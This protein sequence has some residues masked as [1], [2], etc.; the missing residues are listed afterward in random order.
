MAGNLEDRS[1]E[2]LISQYAKTRNISE[3]AAEKA[4]PSEFYLEHPEAKADYRR[5][6]PPEEY[7]HV[8]KIDE[9]IAS[10]NRISLINPPKFAVIRDR[11]TGVPYMVTNAGLL[12]VYNPTDPNASK[13]PR[14][15][16]RLLTM[17]V[18][19]HQGD[20]NA[21]RT[22]YD[23]LNRK[24]RGI[25]HMKGYKIRKY[26]D[27]LNK[28]YENMRMLLNSGKLNDADE[29]FYQIRRYYQKM[30]PKYRRYT[31]PYS[32]EGVTF[33]TAYRD[34][35][36]LHR[37]VREDA[38]HYWK[39][40][41]YGFGKSLTYEP[42][43]HEGKYLYPPRSTRTGYHQMLGRTLGEMTLAPFVQP[44][45]KYGRYIG[46]AKPIEKGVDG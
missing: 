1:P 6:I 40:F 18:D 15:K 35:E 41:K 33:E 22:T 46:L 38:D 3:E 37:T 12:K 45:K 24:D 44:F 5:A 2:A 11:K 20:W 21:A 8:P 10:N 9:M 27:V 28:Q 30:P 4:M 14:Y 43:L 25:L 13:D 32:P 29:A 7:E 26:G 17:D 34:M 19:L 31:Y 36:N 42:N 23:T 16:D 39:G